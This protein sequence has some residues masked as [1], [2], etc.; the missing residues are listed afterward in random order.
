[1][2]EAKSEKLTLPFLIAFRGL[3]NLFSAPRIEPT[4]MPDNRP[5]SLAW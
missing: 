1:M 4:E 2:T 5:N 3:K